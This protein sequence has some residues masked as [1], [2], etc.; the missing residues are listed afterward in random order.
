[1]R[2]GMIAPP[3]LPVPPPAYGGTEAVLDGLVRGL[4]R[5]PGTRSC[6]SPTPTATTPAEIRSVLP[7]GS[8]DAIGQGADRARPRRGRLRAARRRRRHPR[9]HAARA[10][11]SGRGARGV[12]IVATH[13]GVF[14]DRDH[15]HLPATPPGRP[16]SSP[17]RTARRPRRPASRSPPSCTTG[18]T[19]RTSRW[20]TAT[21]A[22]WPSSGA[23][24]RRRAPITPSASPGGWGCP[25]CSRPRC[26]RHR[27]W[28]SSRPRSGTC[29]A[30]T[31][32]TSA[33]SATATSCSCC[34]GPAPCSTPSTGRSRS[35]W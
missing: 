13:H 9:P 17:S 2:I 29:W 8:T 22:T 31:S 1:M 34:A 12:P 20:A 24:C 19:S 6:W 30:G 18:S 33:S 10:R 32:S 26:A 3:W 25:S 11:C 23:W 4:H 27:R 5:R 15:P 28:P 21:A 7:R 16:R 35:G 14:D